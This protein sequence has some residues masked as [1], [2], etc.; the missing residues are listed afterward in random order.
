MDMQSDVKPLWVMIKLNCEVL[1]VL[2]TLSLKKNAP[3]KVAF[4]FKKSVDFACAVDNKV[5]NSRDQI[6]PC[7]GHLTF[8]PWVTGE[9][10][11][12]FF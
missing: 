4:L 7:R 2:P 8:R 6:W 1:A 3:W 12:R 10:N 5:Q 9:V 11:V